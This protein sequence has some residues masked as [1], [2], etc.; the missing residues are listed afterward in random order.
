MAKP[1]KGPQFVRY[2]GPV[3]D[4]LRELGN[5]GTPAEVREIVAANLKLPDDVLNEQ[6]G[7]GSA[8]YDNQVAWARFYL[9][10]DGYLESSKRGVWRLTEK[11]VATTLSHPQALEVFERVHQRFHSA[12]LPAG[13]DTA[14]ADEPA[15]AADGPVN[16]STHENHRAQLLEVLRTMSA[17]SFEKVC[18][19]LLRESGFLHVEVTGRSGDCGIDGKGILQINP[20]LSFR[21]MFQC[22]RYQDG[23]PITPT[24]M[25]DFRG[26]VQGRADKGIFITTSRFTA[27]AQREAS[28][29]GA[30][31]IE[32]V[33]ADKLVTMFEELELGLT[34][35]TVYEVDSTFF[36]D[37]K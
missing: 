5:S 2:F 4:A 19:R 11:G 31:P 29:D 17:A 28:R 9:N 36:D 33:D 16:I 12:D 34:P 1:S 37:F 30:P 24:Q 15:P 25:R 27:E 3:L 26:A 23:S 20:L 32:L 22:K 10:K 21:V 18:Q 8:R 13:Q 35:K 6:M 14:S 7:G